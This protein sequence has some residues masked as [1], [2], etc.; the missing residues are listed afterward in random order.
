MRPV[1]RRPT[2][3]V[4]LVTAILAESLRVSFPLLAEFADE[5]GFTTAAG[6]IPLLFAVSLLAGPLAALVGPRLL[7]AIGV[8]GL[9][10]G[11]VVMQAQFTPGLW[12]TL[13]TVLFGFVAWATVTRLAVARVGPLP[14]ASAMFLGLAADTA[15]RL[16]LTTW[17]A[18]WQRD[19]FS[20]VVGLGLPAAAVVLLIG[21]MG[22]GRATHGEGWGADV[23]WWPLLCGLVLALQTLIYAN[24]AYIGA[25]AGVSL[26]VA[27][28]IVLIGLGLAAAAPLLSR[29]WSPLAWLVLVVSAA[30]L[31]GPTGMSG[32]P[33]PLGVLAGQTAL[34]ALVA[35][36]A[37]RV[38]RVDRRTAW[39]T[40]LG[41]GLGSLALVLIIMPYQISYDLDAL[42]DIPQPLWPVLG[43]LGIVALARSAANGDGSLGDGS[44]VN[45]S[46]A[47]VPLPLLAV[48]IWLAVT[49]PTVAAPA[50]DGAE[51]R[52]VTYNL[53]YS[54][55]DF[56]RLDPEQQARVMEE[57]GAR[58]L[59]LQEVVRGWPIGGGLDAAAW[60][61]RRLGM[62]YVYG[63]AAED[64]FGN[65]IMADRPFIETW[66]DTMDRGEGPMQRG[67]VAA[68]LAIG[69]T[70]V[71]V[72]ST[73]LQHRD[74][75][76]ATRHAQARQVLADWAGRERSL[77]GGDF[78]AAPGEPDLDPWFDGTGLVSAEETAAGTLTPT[79]PAHDPVRKID[80]ILGSP[81]LGFKDV[82]VPMT[83]ASDHLP[84]FV[85][86]LIDP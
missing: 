64:R 72:W 61:S 16:G 5:I 85:T 69:D 9:A 26:P 20:W 60:L 58:V 54:I 1:L 31:S 45:W 67:F 50:G 63:E 18:A 65:A 24:L 37:V 74:D 11:R 22:S 6:V 68:T 32:W 80:W 12:V 66:S 86:V 29:G 30:A 79:S 84:V 4:V 21:V 48:P 8:V 14:A 73:H 36:A 71:Y 49:W 17:D 76:T 46:A 27:G 38:A 70:T 81:D 44:R 52:V 83:R 82:D 57:G 33:V 43:A 3:L 42:K 53:Q 41:A 78:N 47:L 75:T 15:I 25:G 55:D 28:G 2:L 56:G 59:M 62:N 77:I 19:P 13:A 35:A 10:A 7:T 51:V 23:M 34:G 39:R 40:G